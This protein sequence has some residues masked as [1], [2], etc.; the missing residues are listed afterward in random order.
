MVVAVSLLVWFTLVSVPPAAAD[1]RVRF[2]NGRELVVRE[3]WFAGSQVWFSRDRGA[4]GVPLTLV[5][6]IEAVDA[7]G[8]AIGSYP[9]PVNAPTL[10]APEPIR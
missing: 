6:A 3:H 8:P 9:R 1:V 2:V 4:V 5:A 10:V 7:Q